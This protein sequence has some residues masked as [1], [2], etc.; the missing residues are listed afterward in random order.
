MTEKDEKGYR[1]N[2]N[3]RF[4][5][6][7]D[8]NDKVRDHCHLTDKYKGTP[9]NKC[10]INVTQNQSNFIPILFHNFSNYECHLFFR[11]IVDKIMLKLNLMLSLEQTKNILVLHMVVVHLIIVIDFYQKV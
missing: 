2:N 6:K 7:E 1:N 4:C 10:K 5:E 3:C 8:V 11:K 9:Q